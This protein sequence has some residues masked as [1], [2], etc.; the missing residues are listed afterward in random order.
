MLLVGKGTRKSGTISVEQQ[1]A[2]KANQWGQVRIRFAT[3]A[4]SDLKQQGYGLEIEETFQI[5]TSLNAIE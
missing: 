5:S 4:F 1:T 3:A 2:A